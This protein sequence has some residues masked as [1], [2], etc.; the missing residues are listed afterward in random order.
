[1]RPGA[2]VLGV[3]LCIFFGSMIRRGYL[4][5]NPLVGYCLLFI[6]LTSIGVSGLRSDFGLA[7]STTS[8]Y[9]IYSDLL[10][11]FAWFAFVEMSRIAETPSLR[12]N[13]VFVYV[14]VASA[15]F[16]FAMDGIGVRNLRKRDRDLDHGMT[17][18]ERSSGAQSPVYSD[19][20]QM[21]G[22]PGFDE[23][24]RQILIESEKIGTYEPPPY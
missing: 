3:A 9:R 20:G 18:F 14:A 19:D 2:I 15:M 17:H 23:H 21:Q 10:L 12:R 7:Q 5:K 8:R 24:A 1:V 4:R 6:L 11:I 13:R 22:Y 16:C